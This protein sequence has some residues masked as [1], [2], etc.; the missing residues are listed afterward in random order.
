M[1][2][3]PCDWRI[4]CVHFMLGALVLYV[5]CGGRGVTRMAR[6]P[7]RQTLRFKHMRP[8]FTTFLVLDSPEWR[9]RILDMP[10]CLL[11]PWTRWLLELYPTLEGDE[12]HQYMYLVALLLK[13][14]ISVV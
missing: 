10:R 5:V 7:H 4:V 12:L 9:Q 13:V 2:V 6:A 11:D 3:L 8:P 1:S 14:D